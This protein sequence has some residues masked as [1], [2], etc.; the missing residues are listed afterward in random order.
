MASSV[1]V[2]V[3][4]SAGMTC[5]LAMTFS[6]NSTKANIKAKLT[7]RTRNMM[8]VNTTGF[9]PFQDRAFNTRH[10]IPVPRIVE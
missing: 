3:P 9:S 8:T 6:E 7:I 2:A 5:G 1:S 10:E 4:P